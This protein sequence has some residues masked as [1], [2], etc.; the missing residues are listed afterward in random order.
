MAIHIQHGVE[1]KLA[2]IGVVCWSPHLSMSQACGFWNYQGNGF[3]VIIGPS[4]WW[5]AG[6]CS[7]LLNRCNKLNAAFLFY[8]AQGDITLFRSITMFYG[9]GNIPHNILYIHILNMGTIL[10]N[11]INPKEHCHGV[12]WC[13]RFKKAFAWFSK[14]WP[15]LLIKDHG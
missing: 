12:D 14:V 8:G 4:L 7:R 5:Y 1:C 6:S 13:Y 15:I 9:T 3:T 11:T 10:W 2:H